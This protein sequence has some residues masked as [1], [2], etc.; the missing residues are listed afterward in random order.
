[1][2]GICTVGHYC[3][4]QTVTPIICEDGMYMNRT[5]AAVCDDCPKGFQCD[6]AAAYS[7]PIGSYCPEGTGVSPPPC[8]VGRYGNTTG[9]ESEDACHICDAGKYCS[10]VG[11]TYPN[12]LCSPGFYCPEGSYNNLGR[13]VYSANS[14]CPI[15]SYCPEGT[16]IP[17]SCPPGTFNPTKALT[18]ITECMDCTPGYYCYGFNLSTPTGPCGVGFYCSGGAVKAGPVTVAVNN[19]TNRVGGGG[20][21]PPGSY[22][23]SGT[24]VPLGCP[25]GTYAALYQVVTDPNP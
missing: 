11:L 3:P 4:L 1:M 9:L 24:S 22:C 13:T 18:V 5:G 21:C 2:Y 16:P 25:T 19:Y 7:C 23:P 6:N 8:P 17:M 12:G 10:T 20:L 15:G 14:T